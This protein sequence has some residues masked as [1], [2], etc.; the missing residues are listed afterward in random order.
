MPRRR[1]KSKSREERALEV[2]DKLAV[3]RH[4][5]GPSQRDIWT[6]VGKEGDFLVTLDQRERNYCSCYDFQFR[7]LNGS[8]PMCYH[9]IAL[10]QAKAKGLHSTV[11][12]SDEEFEGFIRAL[13]SDTASRIR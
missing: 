9:L 11:Q 8:V 10:S 7:V 3:K 6:V 4:V 1:E 12:F 2:L 13:V 5:F